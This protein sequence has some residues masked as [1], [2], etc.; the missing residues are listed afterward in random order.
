MR[1]HIDDETADHMLYGVVS[2]ATGERLANIRGV[3]DE[4]HLVERNAMCGG[5]IA[6]DEYGE[7]AVETV[8]QHVRIDCDARVIYLGAILDVPQPGGMPRA[9]P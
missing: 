3:D 6:F 9:H 2:E 1:I 8:R 7:I 4:R 5:R